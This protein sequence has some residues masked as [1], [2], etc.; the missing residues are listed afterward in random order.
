VG[1]LGFT[2]VIIHLNLVAGHR[3]QLR[4]SGKKEIERG[5]PSISPEKRLGL[6]QL[7]LGQARGGGTNACGGLDRLDFRRL[8]F[9]GSFGA[10]FEVFA[11]AETVEVT[12]DAQ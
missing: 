3:G 10:G 7:F 11:D 8:R 1:P 5:L 6:V 4:S 12:G 2:Q 9:S